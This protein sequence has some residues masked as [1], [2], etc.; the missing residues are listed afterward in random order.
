V[1]APRDLRRWV[2]FGVLALT[3][4]A[5]SGCG[6]LLQEPDTGTGISN[7]VTVT[8]VSGNGQTGAPGTA[9]GQ[10]LK[11]RLVAQEDGPT[12]RLWVEW[13]VLEG[14]GTPSPQ[15]SFTD[16]D[17]I[18]ETTWILGP[19]PSRQRIMARFAGESATFEAQ[20]AGN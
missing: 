14:G 15:H 3:W 18:A 13:V 7:L 20:L 16:A 12:E 4:R 2:V 1:S 9:L 19:G 10:P 17:G 6:D 8:A 5:L 11:V